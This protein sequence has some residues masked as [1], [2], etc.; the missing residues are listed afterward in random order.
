[1][2]ELL[3]YDELSITE[4]SKAFRRYARSYKVETVD[5][6]DPLAQLQSSKSS[7][8]DLFKDLLNQM[9]VL[10]YQIAVAVLLSKEKGNGDTEYSSVYFNSL[11]KTVINSEFSLDKSFQ[12]V[13]YRINNWIN[14][15]SAWVVESINGE[16]V[17][18]SMYSPLIGSCFVE[19]PNELKNSK[20]GLIN[21]K[22]NDNKCFLWC[23]VRYLN[24]IKKTS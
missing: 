7:I 6:R 10:K 12:E 18:I 8:K 14:E 16:Y 4:N 1:M 9:K 24:L 2:H 11:T 3:F 22:N 15:G 5:S 19:L 23:H 20:K 21:F 17:N 13:L